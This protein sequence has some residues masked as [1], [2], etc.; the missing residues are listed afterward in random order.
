MFATMT[1][2]IH[3]PDEGFT[4][5][6]LKAA[7]RKVRAPNDC[8]IKAAIVKDVTDRDQEF[9]IEPEV[10]FIVEWRVE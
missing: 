4:P 8:K 2:E 1:A 3:L 5:E 10:R 9:E 6:D 7:L